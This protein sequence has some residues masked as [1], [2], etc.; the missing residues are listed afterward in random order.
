[1][2]T[3]NDIYYSLS[4]EEEHPEVFSVN[5]DNKGDEKSPYYVLP[6]EDAANQATSAK[7][8]FLSM[9]GILLTPVEGWKK[10]K[11]SRFSPEKFA[12]NC[13]YPLIALASVGVFAKMF[14]GETGA[15]SGLLV[16][17]IVIFIS[18]FLGY[19]SVLLAGRFF[20]PSDCRICLEKP[21]GKVFVMA[22]MST[23]ALFMTFYE[24][25]PMLQPV[26]CFLPLWTIYSISR[27]IRFLRIPANR[28]ATC[29]VIVSFMVIGL[30]V[31]IGWLFTEFLPAV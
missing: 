17:A 9:T 7:S 31:L 26:L 23:L 18:L 13:F 25:L 29:T 3:D 19:F 14:Y 22:S 30:P 28:Q 20:L 5:S 12:S 8:A 15:L 21:F 24:I 6:D 2:R 11:R 16:E 1:M 4:E 10:L 27:G